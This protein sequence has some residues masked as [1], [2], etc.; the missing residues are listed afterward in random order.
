M[1]LYHSATSP[2]VRKVMVMIHEAGITGITLEGVG[3]HAVDPGTM[4]V[5]H[6]PLGKIPALVTDAGDV[7]F[8]SRVICQFL[9]DHAGAGFYPAAPQRWPVLTL[10]ALADGMLEAAVLM[11]YESRIR[12]EGSQFAPWVEGQWAKVARALDALETR[13]L[14]QLTGPLDAAQIAVGC[15]LGYVDFRHAD[16]DWRAGRLCQPGHDLFDHQ[17]CQS[18]CLAVRH[19]R[20]DFISAG[21]VR[22]RGADVLCGRADAPSLG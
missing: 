3:G 15:A 8:D 5:A 21:A 10:E 9:D 14:G 20:T 7:L 17:L 2:F 19:D 22:Q 13:Y 18:V 6:N 11:V 1:K 12:P 16:R 4:P